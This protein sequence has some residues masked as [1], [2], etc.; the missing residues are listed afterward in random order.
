MAQRAPM[1]TDHSIELEPVTEPRRSLP[2]LSDE[3]WVSTNELPRPPSTF[4]T[5]ITR[6]QSRSPKQADRAVPLVRRLDARA[7]LPPLP[8]VPRRAP[9]RP[10]LPPVPAFTRPIVLDNAPVPSRK[11]RAVV[12]VPRAPVPRAPTP[13]P[14]APAP[15]S[16]IPPASHVLRYPDPARRQDS[17]VEI[18]IREDLRVEWGRLEAIPTTPYA[19]PEPAPGAYRLRQETLRGI[20]VMPE[21]RAMAEHPPAIRYA[22]EPQPP[23]PPTVVIDP[24]AERISYVDVRPPISEVPGYAVPPRPAADRLR[25]IGELWRAAKGDAWTAFLILP[26]AVSLV[27]IVVLAVTALASSPSGAAGGPNR[28][29]ITASDSTGAAITVGTAFVDG[30]AKCHSLPCALDLAD[31]GH[32]VSVAAPGYDAPASRAI[33]IGEDGPQQIDFLLSPSAPAPSVAAAPLAAESTAA[34]HSLPELQPAAPVE[35]VRAP[36]ARAPAPAPARQRGPQPLQAEPGMV[37]SIESARSPSRLNINSVPASNVVLDGR[38]LGRTPRLGV[39][40]EPGAHTVV[41]VNGK[42]RVVQSTV[43]APG[44]TA[45]VSTRL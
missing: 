5:T 36:V 23:A 35:P 17:I 31:G 26:I 20:E 41:F 33:E 18:E 2:D 10:A 45:V 9:S 28:R 37:R 25:S 30:V 1:R 40:V 43:V 34:A 29:V 8:S 7:S 13:A 14:R 27:S 32:W 19:H 15:R 16:P 42:K 12:P 6:P 39:S 44:K 21:V 24:R 22:P 38:P 11:A 4:E 3:E